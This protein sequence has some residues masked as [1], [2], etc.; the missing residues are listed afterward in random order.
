MTLIILSDLVCDDHHNYMTYALDDHDHDLSIPVQRHND[1]DHVND[2]DRELCS[3]P[4]LTM[5]GHDLSH[6]MMFLKFLMSIMTITLTRQMSPTITMTMTMTMTITMTITMTENLE[7]YQGHDHDRE[8]DN[9]HD[10]D[11]AHDD[12]DDYNLAHD[13]VDNLLCTRT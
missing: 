3:D 11:H 8:N 4:T 6:T 10:K 7:F 13:Q 2:D 5:P 1:K 12:C 9:G